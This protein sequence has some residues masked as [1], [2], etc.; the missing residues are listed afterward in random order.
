MP[1]YVVLENKGATP[2]R[3]LHVSSPIAERIVI[4]RLTRENGLIR[5]TELDEVVLP[6][7]GRLAFRPRE[8]QIT[9]IGARGVIEPGSSIP[10]TF[11]FE[12][13][14]ELKVDLRV[15]NIGDPEHSDHF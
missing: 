14:G 2:E 11:T 4:T 12:R 7:G 15:E 10:L 13:S 1:M 8:R 5:A 3:L 9:L 6:P